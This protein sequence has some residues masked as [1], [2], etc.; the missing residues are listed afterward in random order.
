MTI[1]S[2]GTLAGLLHIAGGTVAIDG[3]VSSS[4]VIEFTSAG[5]VLEL[6]NLSAFSAV[7]SGL[8]SSSQKIDLAGFAYDS[9]TE[10][11]SWSQ[12][13][14]SGT[15]TV[16]DGGQVANLTLI[17]TYATSDFT[18]AG[19]GHGG[20]YVFDPPAASVRAFAQAAAAFGASDAANVALPSATSPPAH[21]PFLHAV[22]ATAAGAP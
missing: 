10:S 16:S 1:E 8:S 18:L 15:L 4:A 19:D 12:S 14:T 5:G 3:T 2:G 22:S 9:S 6:A 7:I 17:G 11:V 13:G 21:A 20:T